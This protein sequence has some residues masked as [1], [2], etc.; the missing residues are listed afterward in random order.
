M[1]EKSTNSLSGVTSSTYE[2]GETGALLTR[3]FDIWSI[4]AL[5]FCVLGTWSTFA[6]GLANGLSNGGPVAILWGL[7][8]VT[9]CN[10][11]IALSIGEICSSMPS[12]LGQAYWIYRL[13]DTNTGRFVSYICAWI[14]T[15]GWWALTASAI[16]FMSNFLLGMKVM[17]QQDWPGATTGWLQFVVY[18]AITVVLTL[19]N[20]VACR[21]DKILPYFNDFVGFWFFGLFLVISIT[22]LACTGE[23]P[24]VEFQPVSFALGGWINE[25][26]WSNGVVWFI[27]LLQS[28]YGLTAFDSIVHMI[29]EIPNPRRTGPKAIYLAVLISAATGFLFMLVCMFCIQDVDGVINTP[30]GLP[31]IQ[32]V[33]D[34]VGLKGGAV[35]I[36]FYIFNAIGQVVGVM[37]T[38]SRLTWGFAR[39]GGIPWSSYFSVIDVEWKVPARSLVLQ[40]VII[41]LIGLLYLF[42][43]FV[44]E[45]I[46]SVSTI[47]LTVSYAMPIAT[48]IL[49]GRDKL[50]PGEFHLGSYGLCINIISLVYCAITTVFFF[51]PASPQP[52]PA[53]M[54]FAIVLFGVMLAIAI[55]FWIFK[56]RITYLQDGPSESSFQITEPAQVKDIQANLYPE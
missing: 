38:A 40:A 11:C 30:T 21:N 24:D 28:A 53:D 56:G 31:F 1:V 13:W 55:V 32:L 48:L 39:D 26:G 51:F 19:F 8:L 33:Q 50:P 25:T 2:T 44:L 6:Q 49:V 35:L 7:C 9:V 37:T 23:R 54:N 36:A 46:I 45:A 22:L 16:A 15:F 42:A 47:A 52:A 4:L 17:F 27:G 29:E 34:V 12:A 14:S 20:L 43:T 18:L 5:A 41:G 10:L 3:K